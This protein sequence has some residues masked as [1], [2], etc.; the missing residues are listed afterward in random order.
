MILVREI[1]RRL[2]NDRSYTIAN[3]KDIDENALRLEYERM[4]KQALKDIREI[5]KDKYF[6]ESQAVKSKEFFTTKADKYDKPR[7]IM[8]L[9]QADKF[10]SSER[11]NL[12]SLRATQDKAIETLNLRGYTSI[13]RENYN[14]FI[15]FLESTNTVALSVLRYEV[16]SS[17]LRTGADKELRTELFSK[18]VRKGFP[19]GK[20]IN[21]FNTLGEKNISL[22]SFEHNFSYF[23]EHMDEIKKLPVRQSGRVVGVKSIKRMLNER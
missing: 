9:L 2:T 10:L 7:L 11:N 14:D 18:A 16:L 23:V 5:E 17:G 21:A 6:S 15:S 19:V 1:E 12:K 22:R 3:L 13:N 20:L 4:R 8:K